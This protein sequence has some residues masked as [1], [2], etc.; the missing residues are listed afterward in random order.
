MPTECRV[1]NFTVKEIDQILRDYGRRP[2]LVLPV[3]SL[4]SLLVRSN[5][6]HGQSSI[7][8]TFLNG[9]EKLVQEAPLH[10][11]GK[12][13]VAYCLENKVPPPLDADKSVWSSNNG[14]QLR[15]EMPASKEKSD[16]TIGNELGLQALDL[17]GETI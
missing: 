17:V 10:Y 15:I 8:L 9:A 7:L 3:G 4:T 2:G 6:K 13:L 5:K 14:L 16:H 12:C 11:I 1:I